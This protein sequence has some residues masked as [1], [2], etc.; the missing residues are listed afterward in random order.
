MSVYERKGVFAADG[1]IDM[2]CVWVEKL[3]AKEGELKGL[4]GITNFP[5]IELTWIDTSFLFICSAR[6]YITCLPRVFS[7]YIRHPS[8]PFP[9]NVF[10]PHNVNSTLYLLL[11]SGYVYQRQPRP[12]HRRSLVGRKSLYRP[13]SLSDNLE[14][15]VELSCYYLFM[16]LGRRAPEHS[17]PEEERRKRL[18]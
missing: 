13:H 17:V 10:L 5:L 11:G 3:L 1:G 16:Y 7:M 6:R 15:R 8:I 4:K 2:R 18:D 12:S 9:I 14:H